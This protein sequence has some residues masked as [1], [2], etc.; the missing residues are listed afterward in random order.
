MKLTLREISVIIDGEIDGDPEIEISGISSIEL[1]KE[2]EITFISHPRYMAKSIEIAA[3]A[4]ITTS[5]MKITGKPLIIVK[6]PY[7]AFIKLLNLFDPE[8]ELKSHVDETAIIGEG[9]QLGDD[10]F[11][12]AQVYIGKN[13]KIGRKSV[14]FPQNYIGDNSVIGDECKIYPQVVIRDGVIIGNRVI[15]HSGTVVGSDGF[16]YIKEENKHVK[17]PQRGKVI[18]EDDVEIG[19]GVTIDRATIGQTVIKRG[20]KIDNLV[21]IAHNVTIGENCLIVAQVGIS[22]STSLGNNVTI[23]GQ[24]GIVDHVNIGDNTI[25]GAKSGVSKDIPAG[26]IYLGIP[27]RPIN[28]TKKVFAVLH[29][30]PQLL[31]DISSLE[32]KIKEIEDKL[33]SRGGANA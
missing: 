5:E 3:S 21:Q 31:R 26:S 20:T 16:G 24:A 27:A 33:D 2:G 19:A 25:V 6:N 23:A 15:I 4:V 28:E 11:I 10:I 18:I 14:I 8:E 22:G 12:G 13:V 7:L 30:L 29:K 1:S 32:R 17:I 9:C